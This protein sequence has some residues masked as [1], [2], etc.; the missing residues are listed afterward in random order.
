MLRYD[1]SIKRLSDMPKLDYTTIFR[2]LK[3]IAKKGNVELEIT[4]H[5]PRVGAAVSMAEAGVSTNKIKKAGD[6]KSEIMPARYT[7]Q[8]NIGS[9]MEELAEIFQR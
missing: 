8:A 4:G 2:A 6:W 9:G 3:R 7:E 5:S 1:E